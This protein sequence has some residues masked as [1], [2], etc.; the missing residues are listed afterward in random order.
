V[1]VPFEEFVQACSPRLFRTGREDPYA[2]AVNKVVPISAAT[3]T[4]GK[5]IRH[6]GYRDPGDVVIT[7]PAH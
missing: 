3:N 5:P 2:A 6:V 7:P 4:P 1:S